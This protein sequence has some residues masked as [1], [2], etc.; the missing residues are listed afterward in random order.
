MDD[1]QLI[2]A[3]AP[4]D[5]P[6]EGA[7]RRAWA[8][9][10]ERI[11]SPRSAVGPA[12]RL[13]RGRRRLIGAS[14]AAALAASAAVVGVL[15]VGGPAGGPS[16]ENAY[17]AVNGAARVTA[18]SARSSGTAVVRITRHGEL[19]AGSTIRWHDGDL[20]VS[21]DAPPRLGRTGSGLRVVGGTL[22][23]HDPGDGGWVELGSPTSIDPESGTTPGEYLAATREDVLGATLRRITD[24][25]R[26]LTAHPGDGGS[27]VYSG[28]VAAGLIARESGFKDGQAI[29][30]FP[31]GYV[32]HDEAA[33]PAAPLDVNLT[34][35]G[36]GLVRRIAVAWGTTASAWTYTVEYGRLGAT[37][38]IAA[39]EGAAPLRRSLAP[40]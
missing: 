30:V 25:I 31:F 8:R 9:L 39:P 16:V 29:R 2:A 24:G 7:R 5:G 11:A 32:A 35:G 36:D 3:F 19:W 21:R 12:G 33:D 14:A 22:Y 26:G 15:V 23:G 6:G 40:R 34:V 18:A 17:A 37:A 13:P 4:Q 20:D 28:T 27:T 10:E 1:L 38:P